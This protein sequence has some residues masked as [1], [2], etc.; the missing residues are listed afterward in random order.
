I[1]DAVFKKFAGAGGV[2]ENSDIDRIA[3]AV[4]TRPATLTDAQVQALAASPVLAES[5]AE[6]VAAKLAARLAN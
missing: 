5:I 2:L 4:A 3:A 1:A 6:K